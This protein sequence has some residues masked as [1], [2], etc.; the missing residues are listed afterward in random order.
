M[1]SWQQ[2][3][4]EGW[5]RGENDVGKAFYLTPFKD[6]FRK[7]IYQSRDIPP[8][9]SQLKEILY[10][11]K[12]TTIYLMGCAFVFVYVFVFVQRATARLTDIQLSFLQSPCHPVTNPICSRRGRRGQ[13]C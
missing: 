10:P 5:D 4:L 12:V 11:P 7:K 6:G 9:H 1:S 3:Q 13:S 2:L 8:E